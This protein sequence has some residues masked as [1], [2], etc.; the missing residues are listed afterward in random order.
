MKYAF[1]LL[2]FLLLSVLCSCQERADNKNEMIEMMGQFDS[3]IVA[4]EKGPSLEY[5]Y[6]NEVQHITFP[7]KD[8]VTIF[9]DIY[10]GKTKQ[11]KL[12][13]CH[14]AGYSRGAYKETGILL[15]KLGFNAMAMDQRSGESAKKV[16]NLTYQ[17]ANQKGLSTEYM[18]AKQDI[19]AAIDYLYEHNDNKPIVI[20]GSSYSASL[21]LLIGSKN[22]KVKAIAAF[23]PGE[24]LEGISLKD[25][26]DSI[27]KPLFITSSKLEIPQTTQL[28]S[29]IDT[30]YVTHFKPSVEGVHGARALWKDTEGHKAYWNAFLKFLKENY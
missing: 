25:S 29:G 17:E 12:L 4:Q 2:I 13:L 21:C 18:D 14:Q 8:S 15:S 23:S 7:S 5:L 3:I 19:E 30:T 27:Q 1:Q 11:V 6:E 22:P 24:Y 20:L 9:A 10:Q 28:I 26:L 16:P